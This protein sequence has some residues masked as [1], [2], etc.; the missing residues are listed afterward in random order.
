MVFEDNIG[1]ISRYGFT[2][3][4]VKATV[5]RCKNCRLE[6]NNR[7]QPQNITT[8]SDNTDTSVT[9]KI[10]G[11]TPLIIGWSSCI[12]EL[13]GSINCKWAIF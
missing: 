3:R 13:K 4:S 8:A 11:E 1:R 9:L 5:T 7:I 6:F 12:F 2:Y 10:P